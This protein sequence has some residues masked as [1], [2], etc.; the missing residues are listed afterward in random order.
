M[1]FVM[2]TKT[3]AKQDFSQRLRATPTKPGVYIM[4]DAAGE[5][6]YVGKAASLR[7]RL[8]SY[9]ASGARLERKVRNM[10]ARVSDFEFILTESESEA[11]IL[12]CNLIKE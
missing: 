6:L 8:R 3:A 5:V 7:H 9:F 11:L 10:V 1:L 12:E 4:R 2:P